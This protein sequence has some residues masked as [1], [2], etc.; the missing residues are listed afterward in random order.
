MAVSVCRVSPWVLQASGRVA[1][2][3]Y[4]PGRAALRAVQLIKRTVDDDGWRGVSRMRTAEA[5]A[6]T[7]P[8][9]S[10][11]FRTKVTKHYFGAVG[12]MPLSREDMIWGP[13]LTARSSSRSIRPD[14]DQTPR[15][16][17][18]RPLATSP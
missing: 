5:P 14:M 10:A 16:S 6:S 9:S 1:V 2:P 18:S 4:L 11:N 8:E 12:S 7:R 15:A 3:H 13:R 17:P